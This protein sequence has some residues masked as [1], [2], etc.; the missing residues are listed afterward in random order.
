MR[1]VSSGRAVE[2]VLP[3]RTLPAAHPWSVSAGSPFVSPAGGPI[4]AVKAS[5]RTV[6]PCSVRSKTGAN[7]SPGPYR[8]AEVADPSSSLLRK[9]GNQMSVGRRASVDM[10][11]SAAYG[12]HQWV[13]P[14]AR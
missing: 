5:V 8:T 7:G 14:A 2:F 3:P 4:V 10:A 11:N 1:G 9:R 12:V 13:V 6:S